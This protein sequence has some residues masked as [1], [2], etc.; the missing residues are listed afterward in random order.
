MLVLDF[1]KAFDFMDRPVIN[2]ESCL[3]WTFQKHL[4]YGLA[5]NQGGILL[6]LDFSKAFD[7]LANN[8]GGILLAL[9]FSKAFDF[10][11]WPVIKEESSLPLTFQKHS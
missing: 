1:S 10:M 6:A 5:N 8:Q 3:P 7:I 11:D 4:I 9:D 2:G